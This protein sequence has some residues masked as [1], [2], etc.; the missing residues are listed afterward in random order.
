M[1]SVRNPARYCSCACRQ[2]VRNVRDR[3]RKWRARGTLEGRKKRA[4][5]YQ[6]ARQRQSR[7]RKAASVSAASRPPPE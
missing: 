7:R 1:K 6:V 4:C 2:A 5:E 3:E